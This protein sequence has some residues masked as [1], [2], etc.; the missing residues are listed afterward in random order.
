[1]VLEAAMHVLQCTHVLSVLA[2]QSIE[3]THTG[4]FVNTCHIPGHRNT[5]CTCLASVLSMLHQHYTTRWATLKVCFLV[6]P[7]TCLTLASRPR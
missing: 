7:P 5:A 4:Y 3:S 2:N 6:Y 1:M